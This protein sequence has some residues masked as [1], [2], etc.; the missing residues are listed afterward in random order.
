MRAEFTSKKGF[1]VVAPTSTTSRS[2]TACSNASCWLRLKRWISST[3]RMV[4]KPPMTRRFSAASI[5]RRKSDTVPP[6]ADTSTKVARVDSAMT[7]ASDV[8]PVPAGPKRMTELNVS[9]SMAARSQ[10]PSPTASACPTT[11][12]SVRGRMRTAS[13]ATSR[14]RSFSIAVNKVSIARNSTTEPAKII[15]QMFYQCEMHDKKEAARRRGPPGQKEGGCDSRGAAFCFKETKQASDRRG[16]VSLA[17]V[18]I[19]ATLEFPMMHP[20]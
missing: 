19:T 7:W 13:G 4:R 9:F 6:I 12:S 10:L 15:E 5:S 2:S 3:N 11:S 20:W 16:V 8:L 14:F 17:D 18:S 1:S